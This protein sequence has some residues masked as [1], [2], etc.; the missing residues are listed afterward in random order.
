MQSLIKKSGLLFWILFFATLLAIPYLITGEYYMRILILSGVAALNALA[1]DL[2]IGHVGALSIGQAAFWGIGAYTS[3]IL[4]T[5]LG[6]PFWGTIPVAGLA[7]GISGLLLG[8]PALRLAGFFVAL[9]T[10]AFNLVFEVVIINWRSMTGGFHGI[11]GISPPS[12][13]V[14]GV[15]QSK[16]PYYYLLLIILVVVVW[17]CKKYTSSRTGRALAA[18]K[19]DRVAA[20]TFMNTY[21]YRLLTF[22]ISGAISGIAG[23]YY[24]H[25]NLYI[26]A[27]IFIVLASIMIL[28]MVVIG[29]SGTIGGP[30][31]GGVFLTILPEFLR[32]A[33]EWRLVIYGALL[34]IVI[35][36]FPRGLHG[37]YIVIKERVLLPK[38]KTPYFKA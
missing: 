4:S 22:A 35:I 7:G 2:L 5:Q 15:F 10:L 36:F 9:V 17:F 37:I 32:V 38:T 26:S 12:L 29:G 13:P 19:E 33:D 20:E 25:F 16:V 31:M 18:I 28:A 1:L 27:S 34:L 11:S 6:I 30:I 21:Y 24:A 14:V 23:G 8:L 3:A